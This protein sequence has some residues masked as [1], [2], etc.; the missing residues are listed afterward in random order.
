MRFCRCTSCSGPARSSCWRRPAGRPTPP[1]LATTAEAPSVR[2][3]VF[4]DVTAASGLAFAYR[5]GEEADHYAILESL[6][7]GVALIDYDRDGL[8]DVFLP[9]GGYFDGPDKKTIKGHPNRLVK[10]PGGGG[11]PPRNP[12]GGGAPP[13]ALSTPRGPP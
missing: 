8:L 10:K 4:A 9:G 12:P 5:N 3:P 2:G 6:G 7:G 13:G 1:T 11:V